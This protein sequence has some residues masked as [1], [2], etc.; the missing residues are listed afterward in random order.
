M[1]QAIIR[2]LHPCSKAKD[3]ITTKV[4]LDDLTANNKDLTTDMQHGLQNKL[5][6]KRHLCFALPPDTFRLERSLKTAHEI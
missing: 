3:E 5:S 1:R 4:D 6:S 2:S